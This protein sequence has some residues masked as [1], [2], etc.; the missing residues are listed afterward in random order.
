MSVG[1]DKYRT[2]LINEK[3]KS[4]FPSNYIVTAKYNFFTFLPIFLFTQFRSY[5]NVFFLIISI[6]QQI[7]GV[8]PMGQYTTIVP[9]IFIL[10]VTG[11]KELYEDIVR[12]RDDAKINSRPT[13]AWRNDEWSE[14]KWYDIKVGEIIRVKNHH[15]F[16]ADL[17][18]IC[19][20]EASTGVAYVETVNLDGESNL[21]LRRVPFQFLDRCV[22][23]LKTLKGVIVCDPPNELIYSYHGML[24][25]EGRPEISVN[26]DQI[27]LRGAILR[28]TEWVCGIVVYTGQDTKIWRN[29]RRKDLKR[30]SSALM[31][32]W[33]MMVLFSIFFMLTI[34]NSVMY[35]I[36]NY[37][38]QEIWYLPFSTA[39][40]FSFETIL[41]F[42]VG[43]SF[44]IPISLQIYLEVVQLI[45]ASFIN[46]DPKMYH[47]P[48]G[49]HAKAMTS[50][51]NSDLGKVKYIF[52]DK[53]GTLTQNSLEFKMCS[54]GGIVYTLDDTEKLVASCTDGSV[55]HHFFL[56]ICLCPG[57]IPLINPATQTLEYYSSSADHLAL[58][59]AVKMYGYELKQRSYKVAN[60]AIAG[61]IFK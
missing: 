37:R 9:L 7:P 23:N 11:I 12:H 20:S 36:W 22:E 47:K 33:H 28:N 41:T 53:T 44:M 3:Q 27:L 48:R 57:I 10:V 29:A 52:T 50:N 16:P 2:I 58:I 24:I 61:V 14:I 54:I 35:V 18:L 49:I 8:S 55:C 40:G 43:Y 6:I 34:F 1:N 13:E 60:V 39:K 5:S 15:E 31:I 38:M 32:N 42:A 56:A 26:E 59:S 30:S 4:K 25:P 51:L 21:K 45:Q 19:S 17:L 46:S